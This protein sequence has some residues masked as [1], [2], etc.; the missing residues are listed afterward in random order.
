MLWSSLVGLCVRGCKN[1]YVY[2]TSNRQKEQSV[3]SHNLHSRVKSR[4]YSYRLQPNYRGKHDTLITLQI[5]HVEIQKLVDNERLKYR[6]PFS[7]G[8]SR[9]YVLVNYTTQVDRNR[10]FTLTMLAYSDSAT[11]W[12]V[13]CPVF[14]IRLRSMRYQYSSVLLPVLSNHRSAAQEF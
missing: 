5:T 1:S 12:V 13:E 14:V 8:Q 9:N 10:M 6:G 4:G 2:L 11:A 3:S 7:W